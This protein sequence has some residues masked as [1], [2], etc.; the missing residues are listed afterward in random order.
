RSLVFSLV[1]VA[2]AQE[3]PSF[4]EGLGGGTRAADPED[5]RPDDQHSHRT[6]AS[7]PSSEARVNRRIGG[8]RGRPP[9]P[10]PPVPSPPVPRSSPPLI[11]PRRGILA[12]GWTRHVSA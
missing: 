4:M 11:R 9:V 3:S 8:R 5:R 2:I 12:H 6:S 10:S 1:V 7:L